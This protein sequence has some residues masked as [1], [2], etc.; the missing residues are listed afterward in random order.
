[1]LGPNYDKGG[2]LALD[3]IE[4]KELAD[5]LRN[6]ATQRH[7]LKKHVGTIMYPDKELKAKFDHTHLP[8][9]LSDKELYPERWQFYDV[10]LN[11]VREEVAKD[12][13]IAGKY[14][15]D[16]FEEHE[17]FMD[18]LGEHIRRQE[19]QPAV[20]DYNPHVKE[21]KMDIDFSKAPERFPLVDPDELV[22]ENKEGD[23]LLLEPEKP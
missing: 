23:V 7:T 3:G 12:I 8:P 18:L 11:A 22:D 5:A 15:K 13:Y 21:T 14:N 10:N 20:G 6:F 4:G 9:H 19:K 16:E 2:D 17:R 1:M